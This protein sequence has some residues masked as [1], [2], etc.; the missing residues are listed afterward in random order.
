M[1]VPHD[2]IEAMSAI[3]EELMSE[4]IRPTDRRWVES[5]KVIKANACYK[6]KQV[7]DV[8]DLDVLKHILWLRPEDRKLVF[9]KV[10]KHTVDQFTSQLEAYRKEI[11]EAAKVALDI[12]ASG[13][14]MAATNAGQEA[15]IK[16]KSC[17]LYTSRCV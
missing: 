15:A 13:D 9:E 3:K 11:E 12:A 17:L 2:V 5:L 1:V 6:N 8:G 4:N 7:A 10:T 16:I 14:S